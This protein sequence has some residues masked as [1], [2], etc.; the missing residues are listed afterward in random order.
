LATTPFSSPTLRYQ[1][2]RGLLGLIDLLAS[3]VLAWIFSHTLPNLPPNNLL[4][5]F[6]LLSSGVAWLISRG[7]PPL[8]ALDT[9]G[10]SVLTP[11]YSLAGCLLLFAIS[12]Q[13]YSLAFL[14]F[15]ASSWILCML[16]ARVVLRSLAPKLRVLLLGEEAQN[17][18][19]HVQLE[20]TRVSQPDQVRLHETDLLLIDTHLAYGGDWRKLITHAQVMGVPV[21]P[22]AE[23]SEELTGKVSVELL[24]SSYMDTGGRFNPTYVSVKRAFD[25]FATLLIS[26]LLLPLCGLVAVLVFFD[27]GRPIL[28]WQTRIGLD[29]RPFRMVKFRSMR[30]D[31]ERDG[32]AF[33]QKGDARVSKLGALLRKFRLDELPQFWNVLRGEMSIIGPRPEQGTFVEQFT[34]EIPLYQVRHWVRPGISGWAQVNQGYAAGTDETVE[35]LR[36]D[37]YYIKHFSFWLDLRVVAKTIWT[38]LSGFGAR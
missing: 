18:P 19:N 15:T 31:S 16:L 38:I 11:L 12:R 7:G 1:T 22:V 33:A 8:L 25:I 13:Y 9:Y 34:R 32:A 37:L 2:L 35:K 4:L 21:V 23:I 14:G 5:E 17:P 27:V 3:A 6:W 30:L 29:N 20:V 10:R 24:Q 36:F 28:F 26:P